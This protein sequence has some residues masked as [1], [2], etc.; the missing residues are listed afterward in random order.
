MIPIRVE[1]FASCIQLLDQSQGQQ[2]LASIYHGRPSL[3]TRIDKILE[4]ALKDRHLL[5]IGELATAAYHM[6]DLC[7]RRRSKSNVCLICIGNLDNTS[8]CFD[9]KTPG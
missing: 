7:M 1:S 3:L 5:W 9:D 8:V 4:L 6:L 2:A